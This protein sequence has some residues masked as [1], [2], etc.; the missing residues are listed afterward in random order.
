MRLKYIRKLKASHL[1]K[2]QLSTNCQCQI[3][4]SSSGNINFLQYLIRLLQLV[5]L[6]I[7]N[8][9]RIVPRLTIINK[10][11]GKIEIFGYVSKS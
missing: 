6:E 4:I 10:S 1:R 3:L 2:F 7:K 9:Y 8:D 5:H 11:N